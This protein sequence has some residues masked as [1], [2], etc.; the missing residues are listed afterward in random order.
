MF[1]VPFGDVALASLYHIRRKISILSCAAISHTPFSGN[2]AV[3]QKNHSKK[4][5]KSVNQMYTEVSIFVRYFY[6]LKRRLQDEKINRYPDV[7]RS[8]RIDVRIG[9]CRSGRHHRQG[10]RFH[11]PGNVHEQTPHRPYGCDPSPGTGI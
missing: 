11:R 7:R 2:R 4:L 3:F 5:D 8:L 10:Q 6:F 9:I 1:S